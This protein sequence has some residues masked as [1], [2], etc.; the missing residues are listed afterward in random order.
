MNKGQRCSITT[1]SLQDKGMA[2]VQLREERHLSD[3]HTANNLGDATQRTGIIFRL[4]TVK[5]E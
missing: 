2:S 5:L 4:I 1:R 3:T